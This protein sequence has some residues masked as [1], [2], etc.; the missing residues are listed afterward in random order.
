MT[1]QPTIHRALLEVADVSNMMD[2]SFLEGLLTLNVDLP[3]EKQW[4]MIYL[5]SA[6]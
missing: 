2:V 3:V 5:L 4:E 1:P 6:Q